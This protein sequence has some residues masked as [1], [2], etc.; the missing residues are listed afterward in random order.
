MTKPDLI[1]IPVG[2]TVLV[3]D[4]LPVKITAICIRQ[5]FQVAYECSWWDGNSHQ[6]EWLEQCEVESGPNTDVLRVGFSTGSVG[7][8]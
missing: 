8:R 6:C 4:H 7:G 1:L 5:N 3:G 2:S